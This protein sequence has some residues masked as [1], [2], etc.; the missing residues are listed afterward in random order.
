MTLTFSKIFTFGFSVKLKNEKTN[1]FKLTKDSK[2][3]Y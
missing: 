3:I 1:V 2:Q